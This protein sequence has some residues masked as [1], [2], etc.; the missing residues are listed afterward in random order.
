MFIAF[1]KQPW[2]EYQ[3]RTGLLAYSIL[4]NWAKE[5][6]CINRVKNI[7]WDLAFFCLN[8][9]IKDVLRLKLLLTYSR[10]SC[11]H[12]FKQ[13]DLWVL[14]ISSLKNGVMGVG[15]WC[16]A[17]NALGCSCPISRVSGFK[18]WLCVQ[19]HFL[20]LFTLRDRR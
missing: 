1:S 8:Y 2:K 5:V 3:M 13:R 15:V 10:S 17:F 11:Q 18:S 20:L 4:G 6:I 12:Y 16:G 19:S 14:R 7:F 9:T